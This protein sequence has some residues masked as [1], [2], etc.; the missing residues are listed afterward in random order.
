MNKIT[1]YIQNYLIVGLPFVILCMVICTIN[2]E[3]HSDNYIQNILY[4]IL[5]IN[6]VLWFTTLIFFL[7]LLVTVTP[8]REKTLSR[9]AN[10][11]GRHEQEEIITGRA[12]RSTYISSVALTILF[13]FFSLVSVTFAKL[14]PN[15]QLQN[16]KHHYILSISV[17]F[18]LLDKTK[19]N[20]DH[21]NVIFNSKDYM[22]STALFLTL[23]LAWQLV[24]FNLSA[25]KE[26]LAI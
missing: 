11:Q 16:P 12:S 19:T 21:A 7:I 25:R 10:I 24:G 26:K 23:L 22:P 4:H 8:V 3:F 1:R 6:L 13:L 18:T 20:V 14:P 15:Q 17:G 5:P 2:P 9:L